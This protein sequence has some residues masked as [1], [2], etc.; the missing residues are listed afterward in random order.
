MKLELMAAEFALD[1]PL[2]F[3][4][5]YVASEV[6]LSAPN[7]S[8]VVLRPSRRRQLQAAEDGGSCRRHEGRRQQLQEAE[9]G[10][11]ATRMAPRSSG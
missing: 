10:T 7:G 5:T 11:A 2:V 1:A 6:V 8:E 4:G 3:D 9:D